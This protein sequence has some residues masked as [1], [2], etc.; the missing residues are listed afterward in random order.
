MFHQIT[1]WSDSMIFNII[2]CK[3]KSIY[4]LKVL[5]THPIYPFVTLIFILFFKHKRTCEI[6][7]CLSSSRLLPHPEPTKTLTGILICSLFIS[8][9]SISSS[10][11]IQF[12]A[13]AMAVACSVLFISLFIVFFFL[14]K[15][16][17]IL[18]MFLYCY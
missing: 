3:I 5:F 4:K 18:C 8:L 13:I 11:S 17:I 16:Q 12:S 9:T 14:K 15:E 2:L 10:S 7:Q 6:A 1:S